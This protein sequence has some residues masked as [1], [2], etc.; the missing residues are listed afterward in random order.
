MA[1]SKFEIGAGDHRLVGWRAGQGRPVLVLHG[2][3]GLSEYTEGLVP[4][5]ADGYD[6][7]RYQQRG[8]APSTTEGPFDIE[9]QAEDA[10]SVLQG[11]GLERPF[12]LGHSW[13]GHLAMHLIATHPERFAA[14]LIIDPLGA[15]PDGG[16]ADLGRNLAE[17]ASPEARERATEL[18]ARAMRGE[19]TDAEARESLELF[20]PGYFADPATAPPM[21]AMQLSVTAYSETLASIQDH[22]QRQTLVTRLPRISLPTTFLLGEKSPI[23]NHH[24]QASAALMPTAEVRV[25]PGVGHIPWLEQPGVVRAELDRLAASVS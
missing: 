25:L 4:E 8:L 6:I 20:W 12:L 14:A 2:G 16:E 5:L 7:V 23:P 11:L 13:G 15:V 22:F 17:R 21:P 18:D 10:L 9:T 3:P 24:G 19:G 1:E